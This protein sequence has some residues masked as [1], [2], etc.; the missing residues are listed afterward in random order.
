[1]G[2]AGYIYYSIHQSFPWAYL[3]KWVFA[4]ALTT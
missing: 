4:L 3:L 2:V 1:M